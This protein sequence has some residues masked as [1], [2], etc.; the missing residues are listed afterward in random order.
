M[1]LEKIMNGRTN[2]V[3]LQGM[4]PGR[5]LSVLFAVSLAT[6]GFVLSANADERKA[7]L[8][9]FDV[10]GAG[11]AAFEGTPGTAISNDGTITGVYVDSVAGHGYVGARDGIITTFDVA[12]AGTTSKTNDRGLLFSFGRP[13]DS[14]R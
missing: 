13:C 14:I 5:A 9:T 11:T 6:S 12:G 4:A 3:S 7:A 2:K 10:L 8:V 1:R